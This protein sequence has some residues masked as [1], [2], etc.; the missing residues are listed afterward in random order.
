VARTGLAPRPHARDARQTDRRQDFLRPRPPPLAPHSI[1]DHAFENAKR[2]VRLLPTA[3]KTSRERTRFPK[4]YV[5]IFQLCSA[6]NRQILCRIHAKCVFLSAL[7]KMCIRRTGATEGIP[8]YPVRSCADFNIARERRKP[9]LNE[10]FTITSAKG[11]PISSGHPST[12]SNQLIRRVSR[13]ALAD[14]ERCGHDIESC[15]NFFVRSE[16]AGL[17][18]PW[19]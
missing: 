7:T 19:F 17:V 14:R 16:V 10:N 9:A 13:S 15:E 6:E 11:C 3:E 12:N 18:P 5:R 8:T 4:I 1:A 2:Y